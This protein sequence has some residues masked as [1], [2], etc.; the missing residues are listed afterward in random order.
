MKAAHEYKPPTAK[1]QEGQSGEDQALAHLQQQGLMLIMRNFR[2]KTGE[3]DLIMRDQQTLVFV[4]VR[5][6]APGSLVS[7]VD[8]ITPAKQRRV[9]LTAQFYLQ[10]FA[11][12]PACRIDVVAIDGREVIWL[13]NAISG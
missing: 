1:Q 13:K 10:R 7:A 5:K 8:S 4:E 3:I 9:W 6:R 11:T 2:C 12:P